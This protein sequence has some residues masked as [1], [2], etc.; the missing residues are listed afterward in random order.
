MAF[1]TYWVNQVEERRISML[2]RMLGVN[3]TAGEI[4]SW[5]K[6]GSERDYKDKDNVLIPLSLIMKPELRDNLIKM[7][8]GESMPLPKGYRKSRNEVVVDMGKVT[9]EEFIEFV[10]NK[11]PPKSQLASNRG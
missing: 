2:G 3:F 7:V 9:P 4:R 5:S 10:K 1:L 8:G 11:T 6:A